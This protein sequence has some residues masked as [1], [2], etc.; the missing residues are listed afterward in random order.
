MINDDDNRTSKTIKHYA[1]E[2]SRMGE[3]EVVQLIEKMVVKFGGLEKRILI[4]C[5]RKV[6]VDNLSKNLRI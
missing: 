5:D 4:F 3:M 6:D 2:I 1:V